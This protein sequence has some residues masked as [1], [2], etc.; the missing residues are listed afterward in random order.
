MG[1][2]VSVSLVADI[3][4]FVRPVEA[5]KR[6][7]DDLGDE[8]SKLDRGLDKI[9][10]DA[11]KAAA[12]LKLLN[13][14][15]SNVSAKVGSL[16]EKNT[17]LAVLDAQIRATRSEVRKLT[18]EFVRTGDVEIF[19]KIGGAEGKL[20]GL[21]DVRKMLAAAVVDGGK[22]GSKGFIGSIV[23]AVKGAGSALSTA[24]KTVFDFFGSGEFKAIAITAGLIVAAAV[25]PVVGAAVGGTLLLAA[26]GPFIGLGIKAAMSDKSV[27]SAM[28]ELQQKMG[29][30]LEDGGKAFVPAVKASIHAIG[31]EWDRLS[32]Q[33]A[34]GFKAAAP[35]VTEIAV[36]LSRMLDKMMPGLIKAVKAAAP[37]FAVLR[38]GLAHIGSSLGDMF[39]EM[40][41]H[42]NQAAAGLKVA[43]MMLDGAI[44]MISST[45]GF[46]MDSF[47]A[48]THAAQA[49]VDWAQKWA[50]WIPGVS[51]QLEK[52]HAILESVNRTMDGKDPQRYGRALKETADSAGAAA[53][54]TDAMKVRTDLLASSMA[55]A[56]VKA[57][58]LAEAINKVTETAVKGEQA[59][60]AYQAALD[61]A[62][63]SLKTNGK[64]LDANTEKGRANRQSLLD[65]AKASNDRAAAIYESTLATKGEAAAQEAATAAAREGR[66]AYIAQAM[67]M[68]MSRL[69]AEELAWAVTR[70]P[71]EKKIAVNINTIDAR[72][73][74][75]E[76]KASLAGV[77]GKTVTISVKADLPSGMSMGYLLHH[78]HG[79]IRK[80]QH[81]MIV[82]QSSPGTLIAEPGTGGEANIP[83]RGISQMRAMGLTQVVA[84]SYGF[85][86][87]KR[88]GGGGGGIT[89]TLIG[90]DAYTASL[91]R[92]LRAEVRTSY[93][94][95]VQVALGSG[96]GR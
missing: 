26:A 42:G 13:G 40:S 32:P 14:D 76:L 30:S 35:Y 22:D 15:V 36:G 8:V 61:R 24:W 51:G 92:D 64:T 85:S 84:D 77:T 86:I 70:I 60:L 65:L 78:K 44:R 79:G 52:M 59:E 56:A 10:P 4:G 17:G 74:I 94:G 7:V 9:P 2:K 54:Q 71:G 25:A 91:L 16:G 5:A 47:D 82:P 19:K 95:D 88:G 93:G 80:A 63:E 57:G 87:G 72:D 58:S 38:D 12:A 66:E 28:D 23:G 49:S 83:L 73:R 1:R 53:T 18:D 11:A 68:G 96:S 6:A 67:Q 46:L 45:L 21:Q 27:V 89:V 31:Q 3:A 62:A 50:G 48:T 29:K 75:D 37:V 34:E 39:G 69:K 33:I 90:G 55:Q 20:R 81:G 41:K 43:F